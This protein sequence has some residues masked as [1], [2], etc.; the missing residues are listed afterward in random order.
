MIMGL[1]CGG[2]SATESSAQTNTTQITSEVSEVNEESSL[3]INTD[4]DHTTHGWLLENSKIDAEGHV[5][6]KI[7]EVPSFE[8]K[9][10]TT[11]CSLTDEDD[12][13]AV[14]SGVRGKACPTTWTPPATAAS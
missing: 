7:M 6:V 11:V 13:S 2:V 5:S 10:Y 8:I 4:V 12:Q 9:E 14:T 3:Y 1:M